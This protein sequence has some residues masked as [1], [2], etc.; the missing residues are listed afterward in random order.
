MIVSNSEVETYQH[1]PRQHWYAYGLKRTPTDKTLPIKHGI[2]GHQVLEAY[3]RAKM[4]RNTHG[5][6]VQAGMSVVAKYLTED[7][8]YHEGKVIPTVTDRFLAYTKHYQDEPWN[9]LAVEKIYAINM[10]EG[11][12]YA[13]QLDLLVE[14][15]E[16]PY[17]GEV[18]IVDHKWGYN[19]QT[20]DEVFF[21]GQLPKYIWTIRRSGYPDVKW[22]MVNQIRYRAIKEPRPDQ[23]FMRNRVE[24]TEAKLDNIMDAQLTVGYDIVKAKSRPDWKTTVP[25]PYLSRI[26]C[27]NC[28]FK[29]P[30]GIELDGRDP[31]RTLAINYTDNTY[32]YSEKLLIKAMDS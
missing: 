32:G 2:M 3:Y 21:G 5:E 9:I 10:I 25:T 11:V 19:F 27:K 29:M 15:T 24:P 4:E 17:K 7:E 13:M 20:A 1:C 28:F 22:G 31:T 8:N 18:I 6:C 23:I 26:T 16:G 14:W 30:C 12:D